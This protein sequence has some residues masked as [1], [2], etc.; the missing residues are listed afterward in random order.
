MLSIL[1]GIFIK[2]LLIS[3]WVYKGGEVLV[4]PKVLFCNFEKGIYSVMLKYTRK[5]G[6]KVRQFHRHRLDRFNTVVRDL[7]QQI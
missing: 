6:H 2:F 3:P 1:A 4:P 7:M 5:E